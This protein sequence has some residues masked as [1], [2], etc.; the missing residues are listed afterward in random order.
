MILAAV[1]KVCATYDQNYYCSLCTLHL[2]EIDL[3]Q[4]SLSQAIAATVG[5]LTRDM[6]WLQSEPSPKQMFCLD[7]VNACCTRI[8]IFSNRFA[9]I[10]SVDWVMFQEYYPLII[11][12]G[13][14]Y[15]FSKSDQ[16]QTTLCNALPDVVARNPS[17]SRSYFEWIQ[18]FH[19]MLE[20]WKSRL[21][22]KEG[23][24]CRVILHQSRCSVLANHEEI[25]WYLKSHKDI[26][27]LAGAV[28]A[29]DLVVPKTD[30]EALKKVFLETFKNLNQLVL[31]YIPKFGW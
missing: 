29:T 6:R 18:K 3:L 16:N 22:A 23:G 4:P 30:V 21:Q 12:V 15:S 14:L 27:S 19:F 24:G 26:N 10:E 11:K 5:T 28:A 7:F 17:T 8:S 20:K 25:N 2:Q 1:L 31:K 13:T 9:S